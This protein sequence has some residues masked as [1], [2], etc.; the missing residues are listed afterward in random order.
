MEQRWQAH[1][2]ESYLQYIVVAQDPG[3][4]VAGAAYCKQI[5]AQY[6]FT[7]PVLYDPGVSLPPTWGYTSV[8]EH[9]WIL[10]PGDVIIHF[11]KYT[12][13]TLLESLITGLLG[14]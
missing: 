4:E 10:A 1:K 11:G 9:H 14:S 13:Q 3:F 6:G 8:N 7:F 12:S 2:D 5:R